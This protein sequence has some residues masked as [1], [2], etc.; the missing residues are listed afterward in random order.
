MQ[1][2][3]APL[4]LLLLALASCAGRQN[5]I[6]EP[7][8]PHLADWK[9]SLHLADISLAGGLPGMAL[10]VTDELLADNPRDVDALTRRGAALMQ[11]AR[12]REAEVAY[13]SALAVAP[14]EPAALLGLGRLRLADDPEAA[15]KLFFQAATVN[16]HNAAALNDVGVSR[17]LQG[18]HLA[19]QD[20]YR[21]ALAAEPTSAAAQANLGL[22]TALSGDPAAAERLLRPLAAEPG[23]TPTVRHDLAVALTLGGKSREAASLLAR[24]L[25]PDEVRNTLA[26][27]QSLQQ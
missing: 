3:S 9:P 10:E 4:L 15:E 16:P 6:N 5:A 26:G 20:A 1:K 13:R 12:R 8:P 23:A 7:P 24:D 27:F 21:A 18:H 14:Q 19:A 11:L 22:S 2:Y 17:D 25:P